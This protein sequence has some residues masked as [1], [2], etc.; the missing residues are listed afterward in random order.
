M[1]LEQI[2]QT[3]EGVMRMIIKQYMDT[4]GDFTKITNQEL[5]R[6][7][8]EKLLLNEEYFRSGLQIAA[9]MNRTKAELIKKVMRE[10]EVQMKPLEEKYDLEKENASGWYRYESTATEEFYHTYSTYP[11][12]N[13]VVKNAVFK[14]DIAMWLRIEVEHNL[15]AGF[16]LFNYD[17]MSE[18]GKGNQQDE[19][20]DELKEEVKQYLEVEEIQNE[21][22][23]LLW[24]YLPTGTNGGKSLWERI[25]NFKEMNEAAIRLVNV[26]NRKTFVEESIVTIENTLLKLLK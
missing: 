24:N 18:Y 6:M 14:D 11:G 22:W 10:F 16:C 15:F 21:A 26:T 12:L 8:T 19:I 17:M 7:I 2:L 13:Y 20:N 5:Q 25:P 4:I 1:W 23:W 3:E 9:T